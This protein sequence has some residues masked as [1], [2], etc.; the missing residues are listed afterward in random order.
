M[1][2]PYIVV[3]LCQSNRSNDDENCF[4]N[5]VLR[6]LKKDVKKEMKK[7]TVF[8][9]CGVAALMD[10]EFEWL[11]DVLY[12]FINFRH[13]KNIENRFI[14]FINLQ[15]KDKHIEHSSDRHHHHPHSCSCLILSRETMKCSFYLF[16]FFFTIMSSHLRL[17][18]SK[19]EEIL[20][21]QFALL[22]VCS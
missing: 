6:I 16:Y 2:L 10:V 1:K 9:I 15:F 4:I 3:Y 7:K 17:T 21:S 19:V 11:I 14:Y 18:Y 5:K 20:F 22:S 12:F 8:F 13:K